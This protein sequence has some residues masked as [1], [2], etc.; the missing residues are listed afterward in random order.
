[1]KKLILALVLTSALV[2]LYVLMLSS[3]R[4]YR[5]PL[6]WQQGFPMI[7]GVFISM[8]GQIVRR[9]IKNKPMV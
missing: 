5:E 6:Y 1:M 7:L 9:V 4:L 2:T 8:F 3:G